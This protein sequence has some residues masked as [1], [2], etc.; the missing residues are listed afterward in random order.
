MPRWPQE[1]P[2]W[3]P[4]QDCQF[5]IRSMDSMCIGELPEPQDHGGAL[6]THRICFRGAEDDGEWLHPMQINGSDVWH[7]R[8]LLDHVF[9]RAKENSR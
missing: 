6:N 2:V 5:C 9:P 4:Y 7:M 3:C 8:R 1:R